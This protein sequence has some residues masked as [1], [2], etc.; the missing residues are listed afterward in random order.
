LQLIKDPIAPASRHEKP[1]SFAAVP[2]APN[3]PT[4]ARE[5]IATVNFQV[6]PDQI[7]RLEHDDRKT[8][9]STP[10]LSNPRFVDRPDNVKYFRSLGYRMKQEPTEE[11]PYQRQEYNRYNIF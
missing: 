8:I 3:L 2:H 1:T 4:K 6:M 5:K 9:R 11:T 7:V 10:L